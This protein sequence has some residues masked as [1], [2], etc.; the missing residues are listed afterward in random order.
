MLL[1][2]ESENEIEF[3]R[4]KL[5]D[6]KSVETFDKLLEYRVTNNRELIR[7]I[8]E[9]NHEQYFP[10]NEILIP[11]KDEVFVDAGAYDGGTSIA[12]ARW[13][14]NNYQSIYLVEPDAVLFDAMKLII[15]RSLLS[16]TVFVNKGVYSKSGKVAFY[17]D[18]VS[19]SSS[20]VDYGEDTIE[21][22]TIDNIL[23]GK[24]V[25][26]IKMDIE[27]AE[28]EALEGAS[29]SITQYHPKLAISVYHKNEDLWSIPNYLMTKYPFYKFYL[30]HYTEITT[31]TVLYATERDE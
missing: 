19:G 29:F 14:K 25:S 9:R 27:G 4:S 1:Q 12:F 20:I 28:R 22:D 16:N 8:Y 30:R 18:N 24:R 15:K 11:D 26:F 13:C 3:V 2:K 21:V 7:E 10:N 5:S 31:E 6:K 17:D 23:Q